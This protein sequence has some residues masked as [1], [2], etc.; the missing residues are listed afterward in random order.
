MESCFLL[1]PGFSPV[2]IEASWAIS[3]FNGFVQ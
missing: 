2:P 1:T 3:R